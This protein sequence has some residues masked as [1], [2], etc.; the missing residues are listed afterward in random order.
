MAKKS[1]QMVPSAPV[2][3]LRWEYQAWDELLQV[4]NLPVTFQK[5]VWNGEENVSLEV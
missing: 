3:P 5:V 2:V 4:R 1:Q